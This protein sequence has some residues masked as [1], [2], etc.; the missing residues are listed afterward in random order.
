M[1]W[2]HADPRLARDEVKFYINALRAADQAVRKLMRYVEKLETKTIVVV[3]GD[4]VAPLSKQALLHFYDDTERGNLDVRRKEHRVPLLIWSNFEGGE[5]AVEMSLNALP[6][7]L[8]TRMGIEPTGFLI[9]VNNF[10]R[11]LPV[12]S[13]FLE[14][15]AGSRWAPDAI[16]SRY[17]QWIEDYAL[18][19]YDLLFGE[20]FLLRGGSTD[21][22]A[23]VAP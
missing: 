3:L 14:D 5:G 1:P 10:R 23:R 18:L 21:E 8:L 15:G 4:H 7:Y 6:P 11:K 16:P 9:F 12:F 22:P 13:S 2:L 19:Q 20:E 17:R